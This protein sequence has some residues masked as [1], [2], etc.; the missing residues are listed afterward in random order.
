MAEAKIERT[1][2]EMKGNNVDE[3]LNS[4]V[5]WRN[6]NLKNGDSLKLVEIGDAV[7]LTRERVRQIEAGALKKLRHPAL[8]K[9]LNR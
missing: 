4:L 3:K 5:E 6:E 8:L 9:Q 2:P 1:I 7:G